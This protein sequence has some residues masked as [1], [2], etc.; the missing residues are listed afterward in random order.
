MFSSVV[1]SLFAILSTINLPRAASLLKP[2]AVIRSAITLLEP[3]PGFARASDAQIEEAIERAASLVVS[4]WPLQR[5][6]PPPIL[7][8]HTV[9]EAARRTSKGLAS[10]ERIPANTRS[11]SEVPFGQDECEP[12][13]RPWDA[14][15]TVSIPEAAL[16][17]G[18]RMDRIDIAA[19]G[20][21]ARITDYKSVNPPPKKRRIILGQ[22]SE[23]QRVLWS[24]PFFTIAVPGGLPIEPFVGFAFNGVI[25]ESVGAFDVA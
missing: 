24:F 18:G 17:F 25:R 1:K 9:R 22:G 21:Q 3:V 11:W 10:D 2:D 6:V 5:S 13:E 8:L 23:L 15:I 19:A 20:D 4:S 12:Q 7:W 14:T 16:V